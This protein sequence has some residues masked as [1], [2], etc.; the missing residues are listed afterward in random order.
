MTYPTALD[1]LYSLQKH[2]IKLGLDA[3]RSLMGAMGNPERHLRVFH[4]AGTNGKGSTAA[5]TASMLE[6]AGYR[7]GLYTSPHLVDFRERIKINGR[8]IGE[9]ELAE[10]VETIQNLI[11]SS[12]TP[13]FFEVT[14]AIA[15]RYFADLQVDV[16]V[17]EVGL[18]GRFDAT[19]IVEP[20]ACVI[21]T[22]GLD[23]EEY[24][25]HT[26]EAIAFEKAGIVKSGVPVIMGRIGSEATHVIKNIAAQR[27]APL[28]RLGKDFWTED[29]EAEQFIYHGPTWTIDALRCNLAGQHQL[30]NAACAIALLEA[31]APA[32]FQVGNEAV[33]QG[34]R[35]VVWEGRLELLAG[36][37]CILLD[38]AHN[39]AAALTLARYLEGFRS[40]HPGASVILVWG[41]MR[42]KDHR[43]FI[44][45]LLPHVSEIILTQAQLARS[46]DVKVLRAVVAE[47]SHPIWEAPFPAEALRLA[48]ERAAACDLV[49]V[50]GSLM[51]LGD[52][53]ALLRGAGPPVLRG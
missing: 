35:S 23:H 32:G 21:T 40:S 12:L 25:G 10:L 16:A 33:R 53:K 30:D 50:T 47:W 39:P 41:M 3:M 22:I 31:A 44:A 24:L 19:N 52:V 20:I 9:D 8:M 49:C 15:L 45:P 5:M 29:R 1:Y 42:D 17:I 11:P 38:G 4:V 51:L 48:T 27:S 2:G 7:V 26:L 13:T 6:T 14:T 34:L 36:A 18:G 46:A 28:W 37:P 43:A